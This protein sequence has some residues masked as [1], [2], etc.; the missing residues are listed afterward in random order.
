MKIA[1]Q[2]FGHLRTYKQCYK[3]LH[4]NLLSQYNCDVFMHTWDTL[5]HNTQTWH[6]HRVKESGL[7]SGELRKQIKQ[8]YNPKGLIIE[9]QM[10]K[11][12]GVIVAQGCKISVFGMK[13]MLHSMS[14]ANR[15]REEYEK[16]HKVI[17]DYV[18]VIRPDIL[19]ESTFNIQSYIE[20]EEQSEIFYTTGFYKF[21]HI[22]N[23]FR[24]IGASDVLF[25]SKPKTISKI[26]KNKYDI[27]KQIKNPD[28]S[29]Y[30][31]EY[32]FIYAI[33]KMNITPV[34]INY[35]WGKSFQIVRGGDIR[36]LEDTTQKKKKKKF[37]NKFV[38]IHLRKKKLEIWLLT[39]IPFHIFEFNFRVLNWFLID[40]SIGYRIKK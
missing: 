39:M 28:T 1:V 5:D 30:G 32:S 24:Y 8:D 11:D 31:P 22:L 15:L 40:F 38:R 9:K 12:E 3:A 13:S 37:M 33:E 6:H 23:D 25:F 10:V 16:T 26:Y 27:L 36:Q 29:K 4:R 14:E 34:F 18:I 7:T 20:K 17:Y 19:L 21:D 35:L 2:I